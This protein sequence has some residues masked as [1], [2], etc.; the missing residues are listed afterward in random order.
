MDERMGLQGD[1]EGKAVWG[2]GG[3]RGM[4]SL[5]KAQ[6]TFYKNFLQNKAIPVVSGWVAVV[7]AIFG[8]KMTCLL[9]S[10]PLLDFCV[11]TFV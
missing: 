9:S 5:S 11:L 6:A 7:P 1:R 3:R 4:N 10:L 2:A 8:D